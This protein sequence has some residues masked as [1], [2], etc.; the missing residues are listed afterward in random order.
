MAFATVSEKG[1]VVIPK[2]MRDQLGL[3]KGSKV[4]FVALCGRI[5]LKKPLE[6]PIAAGKGMFKGLGTM[7]EYMEEKRRER[8]EEDAN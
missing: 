8:E 2:Q 3:K 1:W 4:E 6:D 5:Y 7:E